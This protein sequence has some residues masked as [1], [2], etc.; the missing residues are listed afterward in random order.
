MRIMQCTIYNIYSNLKKRD[1]YFNI[2][3]TY[4]L[5]VSFSLDSRAELIVSENG[6]YFFNVTEILS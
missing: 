4:K 1:V 6:N 3:I 2:L 5:E